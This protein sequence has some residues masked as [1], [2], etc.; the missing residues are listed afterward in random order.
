MNWADVHGSVMDPMELAGMPA[1]LRDLVVAIEKTICELERRYATWWRD[2]AG[3]DCCAPADWST[4]AYATAE[5]A[6][7]RSDRA[8]ARQLS[9]SEDNDAWRKAIDECP[10][11]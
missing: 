9:A 10:L 2:N 6:D 4:A 8:T 11:L 5:S 7:A 3:C 1:E